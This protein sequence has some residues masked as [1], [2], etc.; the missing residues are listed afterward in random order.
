MLTI[1]NGCAQSTSLLGP[2]YTMAKSGSIIQASSSFAASYGFKQVTGTSPGDYAMSFAKSYNNN[3]EP[4]LLTKKERECF[5]ENTGIKVNKVDDI[6]HW[7]NID[8]VVSLIDTCDF[9]IS[10]SNSNAHF[11]GALGKETYLLLPNGKGRLWY[12]M[13]ENGSSIW[14]PS[15]KVIEQKDTGSWDEVIKRLEKDIREKVE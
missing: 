15:I 13:Y 6:D 14:Y 8:G 7:N 3:D 9:I 4:L 5:Y 2:S 1:L 11:S 10:I 12:W